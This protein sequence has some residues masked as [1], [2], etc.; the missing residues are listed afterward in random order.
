MAFDDLLADLIE[1]MRELAFILPRATIFG[2]GNGRHLPR[3][4]AVRMLVTQ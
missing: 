2:G 4:A 1:R 3:P